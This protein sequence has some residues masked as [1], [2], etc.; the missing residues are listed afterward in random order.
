MKGYTLVELIIVLAIIGTVA[1]VAVP[2]YQAILKSGDARHAALVYADALRE[3]Q[4]RAKLMEFDTAWGTAIVNQSVVVFSGASYAARTAARDKTYVLPNVTV[5]GATSTVFTKFAG[6][7]S[8][9]ATTTFANA[10]AST[11][12]TLTSGGG[13]EFNP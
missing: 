9:I 7:P 11:T 2:S 8:A 3:A 5:T 4:N 13:V 1:A 10:Y 12:V 6:A